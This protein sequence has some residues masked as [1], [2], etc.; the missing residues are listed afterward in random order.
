[1]TF[2]RCL[3]TAGTLAALIWFP[4]AAQETSAVCPVPERPGQEIGYFAQRMAQGDAE[5]GYIIG[6]LYQDGSKNLPKDIGRA[7]SCFL[8]SA[9]KGY[10]PAQDSVGLMYMTGQGV[11]TDRAKAVEWTRKA[12]EQG[13]ADA[14]MKMGI[15]NESG[16]DIPQNL[17]KAAEWYRKAAEQ[18]NPVAQLNLAVMYENGNGVKYDGVEALKWYRIAG[19]AR[20]DTDPQL[21]ST[22]NSRAKKLETQLSPEDV[23]AADERAMAFAPVKKKVAP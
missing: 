14:E 4:A 11:R 7:F 21:T 5:S 9:E 19:K 12:A 23:A 17:P 10:A 2:A 3:I 16:R 22:A 20:K 8:W 13:Y 15:L 18:G 1:M 6:V